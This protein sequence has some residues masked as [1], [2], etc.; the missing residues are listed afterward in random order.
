MR[1]TPLLLRGLY[2][3]LFEAAPDGRFQ[4]CLSKELS[5]VFGCERLHFLDEYGLFFLIQLRW[6]RR[7]RGHRYPN[8]QEEVFLSRRRTDAE[9]AYRLGRNVVK[10]MWGVGRNVQRFASAHDRL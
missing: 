2:Q 3:P 10:L 8:L 1:V 5:A 6:G 9:H 7:A 4:L